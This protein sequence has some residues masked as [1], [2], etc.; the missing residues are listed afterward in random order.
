MAKYYLVCLKRA[1]QSLTYL[2]RC[3]KAGHSVEVKLLDANKVKME[4]CLD[5]KAAS[6]ERKAPDIALI[7]HLF[8]CHSLNGSTSLDK[9]KDREKNYVHMLSKIK[10]CNL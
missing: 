3:S 7:E 9:V 5:R 6:E 1:L 8:H 4:G 10:H 2:T